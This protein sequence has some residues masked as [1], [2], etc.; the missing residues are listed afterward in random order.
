[1]PLS[2]K[3]ILRRNEENGLRN[4]CE[5]FKRSVLIVYDNIC[6]YISMWT[7]Q[8]DCL[9]HFSWMKLDRKIQWVDVERSIEFLQT[10]NITIDDQLR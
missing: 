2:V 3:T 8:F 6:N 4:E 7:K 10:I 9:L 1:M 5:N